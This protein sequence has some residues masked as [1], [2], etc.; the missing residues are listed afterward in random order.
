M[1]KNVRGIPSGGRKMMPDGNLFLH[2]EIKSI[3]NGKNVENIK[4]IFL[5]FKFLQN[6]FNFYKAKITVEL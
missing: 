6:I 3:Q 2:K 5:I 4:H 1:I